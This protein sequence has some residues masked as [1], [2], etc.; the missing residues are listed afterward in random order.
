MT[1][2]ILEG[3]VVLEGLDGAGTT[4]QLDRLR[5]RLNAG[6]VR[7]WCTCE[8]TDGPVGLLIR[9]ALRREMPL[10]PRT[11]ALLFAADR[12]EHLY[13][14]GS[15]IRDRLAGGEM[16]VSDRYL[17]SSLAYQG[18]AWGFEEVM[19]LHRDYPLPADVVYIDTPVEVCQ[20]RM[21]ARRGRELFDDERIQRRV[22]E[23]YERAFAALEGTG[24]RVHRLDGTQPPE[25]IAHLVWNVVARVPII[26]T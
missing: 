18:M 3:F 25:K 16:V 19:D 6:R 17:F 24:V 11:L 23:G 10:A 5:E 20:R 12:W 14:T 8:P 7:A 26:G 9:A 22:V 13:A 21:A 15:G 1:K 2:G 4:T